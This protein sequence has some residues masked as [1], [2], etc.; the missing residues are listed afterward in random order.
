MASRSGFMNQSYRSPQGFYPKQGYVHYQVDDP[1]DSQI[2]F[3]GD[4]GDDMLPPNTDDESEDGSP[5]RLKK[6][7]VSGYDGDE[8]L[9]SKKASINRQEVLHY[10]S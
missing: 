6:K 1:N 3:H 10:Q 8:E 5:T 4:L 9:R 7:R 2:K